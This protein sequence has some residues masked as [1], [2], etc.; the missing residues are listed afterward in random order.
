MSRLPQISGRECVNALQKA[1]FYI[2]RQSGSHIVMRRDDP[3][4]RTVVPN[5]KTLKKGMLSSIIS[6][7]GLTVEEFIDLL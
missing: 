2:V 7:A 4:A 6:D 1:G 5:H 3:R